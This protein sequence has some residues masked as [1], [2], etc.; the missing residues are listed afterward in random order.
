[1]RCSTDCGD[2]AYRAFRTITERLSRSM[3]SEDVGN[4]GIRLGFQRSM[5]PGLNIQLKA[6]ISDRKLGK[7]TV[8]FR[9]LFC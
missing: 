4:L 7:L 3:F 8:W 6:F 2:H 5:S 9:G 1:M